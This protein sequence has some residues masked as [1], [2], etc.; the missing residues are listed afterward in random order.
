MNLIR[1]QVFKH[2]SQQ[3]TKEINTISEN[4]LLEFDFVPNGLTAVQG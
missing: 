4:L 1:Y 3:L 2:R